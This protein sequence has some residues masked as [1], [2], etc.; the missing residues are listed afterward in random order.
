[1]HSV[2]A[3]IA[4]KVAVLLEDDSLDAGTREQK[5]GHHPGGSAP[6]DA[7][8]RGEFRHD[9]LSRLWQH[10]GPLEL[11][12]RGSGVQEVQEVLFREF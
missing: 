4:E 5:T 10:T 12:F 1:M 8:A 9:G 6:G 11:W 3:K 7:A 2:A